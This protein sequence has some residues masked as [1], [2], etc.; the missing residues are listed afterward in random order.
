MVKATVSNQTQ[1]F[2]L[3]SCDGG[4]IV[5]RRMT[6][7]QKLER[8][9]LATQQVIKAETDRRG[10]PSNAGAEMDVKMLQRAVAE[11]EFSRCIVDHNLEDEEGNKLNFGNPNT[12]NVLDPRVGDEISQLIEDMNNFGEDQPG[13]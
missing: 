10:R 13:N 8:I 6:Y 2:D 11:Y 9:E 12:L 1:A 4:K 7:G 5:L 3:K